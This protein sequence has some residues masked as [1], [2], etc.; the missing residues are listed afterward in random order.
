MEDDLFTSLHVLLQ[1]VSQGG[2]TAVTSRTNLITE[3]CLRL[4]KVHLELLLK[5]TQASNSTP[6]IT[7]SRELRELLLQFAMS[8]EVASA[9]SASASKSDA[10][11]LPSSLKALACSVLISGISRLTASTTPSRGFYT[12]RKQLAQRGRGG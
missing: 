11:P 3:V 10:A 7:R 6:P 9:E 5:S 1:S 12:R 2:S 4:L 8:D